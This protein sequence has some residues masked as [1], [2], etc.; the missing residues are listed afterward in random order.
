VG[1]L[2][3]GGAIGTGRCARTA[4]SFWVFLTLTPTAF[5]ETTAADF[6]DGVDLR[7]LALLDARALVVR[8]PITFLEDFVFAGCLDFAA[9]M[10]LALLATARFAFG[11][12]LA[13]EACRLTAVFRVTP[14]VLVR[15]V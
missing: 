9:L 3:G 2:G 14:R 4:A 7:T 10:G 13:L 5:L 12:F 15:D 6:R 1:C 8:R 11:R